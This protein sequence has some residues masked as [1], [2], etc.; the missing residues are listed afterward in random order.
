MYFAFSVNDVP[1]ES[2]I[3]TGWYP[4][5]IVRSELRDLKSGEGQRLVVTYAVDSGPYAK[6]RLDVGFNVLHPN[7]QAVEISQKELAKVLRACGLSQINDTLELH[8][9]PHQ[10]YIGVETYKD[11]EQN[12]INDWKPLGPAAIP[13][14]R[15]AASAPAPA[16]AAQARN[17]AS[18]AF[19]APPAPARPVPTPPV[20][21]FAASPRPAVA[22]APVTE[23]ET[24]HLPFDDHIPF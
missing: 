20:A 18:A 2:L 1:D 4:A 22:P 13:T 23:E 7:P 16:A 19:Q 3:P 11:R 15:P 6:R 21:P 12:R 24:R 14:V 5:R 9:R 8:D 10:I 17:A